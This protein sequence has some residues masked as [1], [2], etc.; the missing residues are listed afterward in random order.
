MYKI[1][2]IDKISPQSPVTADKGPNSAYQRAIKAMTP[3][4]IDTVAPQSIPSETE[5]G[6][7][8]V[9]QQAPIND[10]NAKG[11]DSAKEEPKATD[12]RLAELERK[13]R[14]IRE[15][16]RQ[17]KA[18]R[19][20]LKA[21][22]AQAAPQPGLMTA[23]QWKEKFLQDPTSLGIG[24]QEMADKYLTQPSE[25]DQVIAELRR[26]IAGLKGQVETTTSNIKQAETQAYENA[27][28]QLLQDTQRLVTT[29]N[30]DF[31][32]IAAD[33]A[34][35]AVVDLIET[36]YQEE[37]IFMSVEE[38]AR[39]VEDYLTERARKYAALK[40]LQS[41][42]TSSQGTLGQADQSQATPATQEQKTPPQPTTRTL[43]HSMSQTTK[44]M[45]PAER[46]ERAIAAFHGQKR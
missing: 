14:L 30:Q 29:R 32:A 4:K 45:T 36:T 22:R 20:A 35:Q 31:E 26:E 19:E 1:T 2:P 11:S 24:Y 3:S 34:F 44:A 6:T 8:G 12:S 27:K 17:V 21:E 37:G 10:L 16:A 18:E 38:A 39:Q 25:Q 41:S 5:G 9:E 13:E 23:E 42:Q 43:S 33:G 40:K 7:Q 28:R 15:E 46:R